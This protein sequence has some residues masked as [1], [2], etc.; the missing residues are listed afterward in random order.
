MLLDG[1]SPGTSGAQMCLKVMS[2]FE[3][4]ME[5]VLKFLFCVDRQSYLKGYL[6]FSFFILEASNSQIVKAVIETGS[7]SESCDGTTI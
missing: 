6:P 2:C 3:R 7:G 4:W 1:T 5:D